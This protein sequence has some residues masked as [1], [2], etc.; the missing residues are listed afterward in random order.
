ME[1]KLLGI[2]NGVRRKIVKQ[3]T[4][5][6]LKEQMVN[7]LIFTRGLVHLSS[8]KHR[9]QQNHIIL[10]FLLMFLICACSE[11]I[12]QILNFMLLE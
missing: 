10:A 1:K 11:N 3:H 6:A 4:A 2:L 5:D 8:D 7:Y 9:D 12:L